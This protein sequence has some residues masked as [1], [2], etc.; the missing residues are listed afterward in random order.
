MYIY[1][2]LYHNEYVYTYINVYWK[3][4]IFFNKNRNDYDNEYIYT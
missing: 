3:K 2:I 1:I 4:N